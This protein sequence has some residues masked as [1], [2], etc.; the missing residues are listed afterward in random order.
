[1]VNWI[2]T[3]T[4]AGALLVFGVLPLV[5]CGIEHANVSFDVNPQG[6]A[7]AFS[8]ADGDLYILQLSSRSLER[9]TQTDIEES[10]PAF[11]PDGQRIAYSAEVADQSKSLFEYSLTSRTSQRLTS[12][13]G[14]FDF[15]PRYSPDGSR[16]VFTRAHRLRP[17]SMGGRTWDDWDLYLIEKNATPRRLTFQNFRSPNEASFIDGGRKIVFSGGGQGIDLIQSCTSWVLRPHRRLPCLLKSWLRTATEGAALGQAT[18]T[19]QAM[20]HSSP[21]SRIEQNRS[22]TTCT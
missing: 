4:R 14:V 22:S 1:M 5:G 7:L 20:G 21:S 15:N 19:F 2:I 9:L 6:T 12:Q 17:Y 8:S 16:I 18:R 3:F 13:D 10:T 11:S